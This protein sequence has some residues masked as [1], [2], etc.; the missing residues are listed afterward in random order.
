MDVTAQNNI[1][2]EIRQERGEI[3]QQLEDWLEIPMVILSL[4]WVAFLNGQ[5]N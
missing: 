5:R 4:I 3:L 1:K 2:G